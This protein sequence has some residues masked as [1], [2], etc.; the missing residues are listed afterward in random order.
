MAKAQGEIDVVLGADG[1]PVMAAIDRIVRRMEQMQKITDG[2]QKSAEKAAAAFNFQP[3]AKKFDDVFKKFDALER[4]LQGLAR[5]NI[6]NQNGDRTFANQVR[7]ATD[8]A[9]PLRQAQTEA[10]ALQTRLYALDKQLVELGNKGK[11]GTSGLTS[12]RLGLEQAS[13]DI[14]KLQSD[15][16]R[17]DDAFSKLGVAGNRSRLTSAENGLFG[18]LTNGRRSNFTKEI[19]ELR[20]ARNAYLKE[21]EKTKKDIAAAQKGSPTPAVTDGKKSGLFG[22]GGIGG[23]VLRTGAY[24]A[25]A[26]AIYGVVGA[27]KD[28]I[29]FSLQ[30]EDQLAKIA[31]IA[32]LTKTQTEGLEDT[33]LSVASASRYATQDIAEATTVLAQAGFTAEDI[34]GSLMAVSNLASASGVSFAEATD[35]ITA[36]IGS[37]QLQA[38]EAGRITD[39]LASAL[40]N[41]KLN[42]QQVALGIQYA[43]ATAHEQ[44][45]SFEELTAVMATMAQAGIRSGSTIGTGLRQFLVDLQT[46]S[47]KLTEALEGLGLSMSDI[48]VRV[49]GL[50]EVLSRMADAGFDS[51]TAYKALETR[52]AAAYIVLRANRDEI[53]KQIIAQNSMGQAAEAAA[54]GQDSFM[55][56]WQRFKNILNETTHEGIEPMERSLTDLMKTFNAFE[57]DETLKKLSAEW[58]ALIFG[59]ASMTAITDKRKE[60]ED[61][62]ETLSSLLET[63]ERYALELEASTTRVNEST[64]AV[65]QQKTVLN[66]VDEA[67]HRVTIRSV[68]LK[69]DS[70]A[71]GAEVATLTNKFAGLANYLDGTA[72]SYDNLR[73]ALRNYRM[74]QQRELRTRLNANVAALDSDIQQRGGQ[75]QGYANQLVTSG[76]QKRLPKNIQDLVRKTAANPGDFIAQGQLRDW[77]QKSNLGGNDK[78]LLTDYY[79]SVSGLGER[80][81]RRNNQLF[82]RDVQNALGGRTGQDLT[83]QLNFDL[84]SKSDAEKKA[85]AQKMMGLSQTKGL[86]KPAREAYMRLAQEASGLIGMGND[87]VGEHGTPKKERKGAAD[88][89]E[90]ENDRREMTIARE[91]MKATEAE[92]ALALKNIPKNGGG[93]SELLADGGVAVTG[94]KGLTSAVLAANLKRAED[95]LQKWIDDRTKLMLAEIDSG[96]MSGEQEQLFRAEVQREIDAK[97]ESVND[98]IGEGLT[99]ALDVMVEAVEKV[100]KAAEAAADKALAMS[101]AR[102]SA[103]DRASLRGRVPDYVKNHYA[104]LSEADKDKRDLQQVGINEGR[105]AG[106]NRDIG[107]LEGGMQNSGADLEGAKKNIAALRQQIVELTDANDIM[108]ASFGG[109]AL[110]PQD[111]SSAMAMAVE[112][113]R[114]ANGLNLTFKETLMNEIPNALEAAST[115]IGTF[116]TDILTGTAT[117]KQAFA[118]F[119]KSMIQ[120]LQ[121]LVAKFI[122][123]QVFKFLLSMIPG[124]PQTGGMGFG[125]AGADTMFSVGSTDYGMFNGG[126]VK[127]A[128][129]GEHIQTGVPGRDSTLRKL[130]K[131]EYVVRKAAVDSVGVGFMKNLN[132]RGAGAVRPAPVVM[133]APAQQEMSVFIVKP[134]TK[135][136]MGPR[137]VLVTIHDDILKD[138]QTK[139]LIRHVAQGG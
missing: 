17:A 47:K 29:T 125:S 32:G 12:K 98:S 28:G 3:N 44:G 126:R 13:K 128:F 137:D 67:I 95:G 53:N 54:R 97:T 18:A 23:V 15:I 86:T 9:R 127:G 59:G 19:D 73:N 21:L 110:L 75:A 90:R 79:T 83:N 133:P 8:F 48:N 41:T 10:Q 65:A 129:R 35:V 55:A 124:A 108:L 74:E 38:S 117:V 93:P 6:T 61:Y 138:G 52:A 91:R 45:I 112:Q 99:K 62:K 58:R 107:I 119:A 111:F 85:W 139:R 46:P 51:A 136:Q 115:G 100:A 64:D 122:A 88:K 118:S 43:G 106:F 123:M 131:G 114:E 39:V 80:K 37:F 135:P 34:K 57:S 87:P 31:A 105:I 72:L 66:N 33:I 24:G 60:I 2:I 78:R 16:K 68:G 103:L 27:L 1:K 11:L 70:L 92:L 36:A 76:L 102:L 84:P 113:F 69:N 134:D 81:D 50:P 40:N 25:A 30:F 130:A 7:N 22:S 94:S 4:R 77:V 5:T 109:E 63:E 96:N 14:G 20:N 56:Q 101:E 89:L 116:F 104:R 121:Q 42:I 120:M 26:A 82:E 49:L 132:E 71:L